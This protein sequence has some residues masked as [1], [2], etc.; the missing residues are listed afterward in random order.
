MKTDH[1]PESISLLKV[2]IANRLFNDLAHEW[3][4]INRKKNQCPLI[5][6]IVIVPRR[7]QIN[8]ALRWYCLSSSGRIITRMHRKHVEPCQIILRRAIGSVRSISFNHRD[9]NDENIFDVKSQLSM[10]SSRKPELDFR[11]MTLVTILHSTFFLFVV[12]RQALKAPE[13]M[14][15]YI[16]PRAPCTIGQIRNSL[17]NHEPRVMNA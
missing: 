9:R 1:C 7:V 6:W 13:L 2:H 4:I 14:N 10:L 15:I 5:I 11:V 12:L 3:E 16:F 8:G 17:K